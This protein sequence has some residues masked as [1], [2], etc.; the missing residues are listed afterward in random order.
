MILE[1]TL[2]ERESY[3]DFADTAKIA[4]EMK[5]AIHFTPSR[6]S[7]VE[8]ESISM[9]IHKMARAV[10]GEFNIDDWVDIAGYAMLVVKDKEHPT[11]EMPTVPSA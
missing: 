11:P 10:N 2:K 4:Q 3:G 6:L 1:Q 9:I 7:D 5:R 8:K